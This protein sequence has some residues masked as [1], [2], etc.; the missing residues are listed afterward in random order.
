MEVA[1]LTVCLDRRN[2]SGKIETYQ[3]PLLYRCSLSVHAAWCY[4]SLASKRPT[5]ARIEIRCPRLDFSLTG[6]QIPMFMRIV[7]L[8]MALYY[9]ELEAKK[10]RGQQ[11]LRHKSEEG[12]EGKDSNVYTS[13]RN[14][15]NKH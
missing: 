9:G 13:D 10:R 6:T 15:F 5:V 2:A 4:D 8:G 1:D 3:E 14:E 11:R 12:N 7:K